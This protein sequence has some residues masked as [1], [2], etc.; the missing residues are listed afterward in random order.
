MRRTEVFV[1]SKPISIDV[2]PLLFTVKSP[3]AQLFTPTREGGS[4]ETLPSTREL[5]PVQQTP[6]PGNLDIVG[7]V[8]TPVGF[9]PFTDCSP[10]DGYVSRLG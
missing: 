7:S 9:D 1:R 8:H 5:F 6:T 2:L 10:G 4:L 3:A